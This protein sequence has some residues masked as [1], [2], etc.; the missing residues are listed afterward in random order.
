M[1]S[2]T[3]ATAFL[4]YPVILTENSLFIRPN[5]AS[6]FFLFTLPGFGVEHLGLGATGAATLLTA[7]LFEGL[8]LSTFFPQKLLFDLFS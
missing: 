7:H 4:E 2:L 6:P 5:A 3:P 1:G 8:L